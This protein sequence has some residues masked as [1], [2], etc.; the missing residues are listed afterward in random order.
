MLTSS[1]S[2]IWISRF[3]LIYMSQVMKTA[4]CNEISYKYVKWEKK[5]NKYECSISIKPCATSVSTLF[6]EKQTGQI[7]V[8]KVK[9]QY[10]FLCI[11]S[12]SKLLLSIEWIMAQRLNRY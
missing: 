7:A 9:C 10:D 4:D 11:S 6:Y 5:R 8:I 3:V 1:I 12:L 2:Y